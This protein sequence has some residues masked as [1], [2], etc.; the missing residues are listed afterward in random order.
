MQDL[1]QF[2]NFMTDVSFP[3]VVL[4][5][6]EGLPHTVELGEHS[7]LDLLVYDLNHWREIFPDAKR[8]FPNP[9]VQFK[10]PVNGSYIQADIR[11]TGD[12]YYPTRFEN[13]LIA[14][15]QWN[16]NGFFIPKPLPFRLA[17]AYHCVHHKNCN[18]YPN[19]LGS[20]TVEELLEALKRTDIGW[21]KPKDHS[22]GKFNP[23]F[24]GATAIVEKKDGK[25]FKKQTSYLDYDLTKNEKRI[26]SKCSSIHFPEIYKGGQDGVLM[27]D[28]GEELTVANLPRNWKKQ[29]IK[30]ILNLREYNIEHR[31]I[32]PNNLMLKNGVI[33]LIDFGWARFKNDPP[34]NPPDCLGYPYRASWGADDNYAMKKVI[35]EL[36]YQKEEKG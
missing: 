29:L 10:I 14:T 3:Y 27:E 15:R 30:I 4:R 13:F 21:A 12:G 1:K 33:K 25:V 20:A 19:W 5:N 36:E 7:D 18:N 11:Y 34:D 35:R 32:R 23:Y 28:C 9:R 24:K 31:D 22:V 8:V 6:W 2:F 26:L 17:L 16:P